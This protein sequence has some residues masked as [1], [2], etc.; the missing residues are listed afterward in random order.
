MGWFFDFV[1]LGHAITGR[2]FT[3][4][5]IILNDDPPG[6]IIIPALIAVSGV[7]LAPKVF[8]TSYRDKRWENK[9]F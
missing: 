5:F 2:F 3:K 9:V 7:A 6:P 1:H 4:F 8:S